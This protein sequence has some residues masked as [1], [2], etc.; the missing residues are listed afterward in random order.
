MLLKTLLFAVILLGFSFFSFLVLAKE[1][2]PTSATA[3][4]VDYTLPYPGLL[5]DHPLFFV[6][7]LRDKILLLLITNQNR[8]VEFYQLMA[9]KYVNM[10]VF[11]AQEKKATL[12]VSTLDQAV[13]YVK[14]TQAEVGKLPPTR[15]DE[16][17]NLKHR[18]ELSLQKYPEV[19][20]KEAGGVSGE[21]ATKWQADIE[22]IGKFGLA[23]MKGK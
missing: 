9:D 14:S 2:T 11:L 17:G 1:S 5:P 21:D 16:V 15:S 18:F 12:A 6:K 19:L 20:T 13:G 23:A 8:R 22:E 4:P 3:S 10:A 7:Q